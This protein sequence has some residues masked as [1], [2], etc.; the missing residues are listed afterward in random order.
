[1]I[2]S[3]LAAAR[4]KKGLSQAALAELVNTN[5]NQVSRWEIG[6]N[7]PKSSFVVKLADA[8]ETST[9]YLLGRTDNDAPPPPASSGSWLERRIMGLLKKRDFVGIVNEL[10]NEASGKTSNASGTDNQA[11]Q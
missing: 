2:G 3:R 6:E 10:F 7:D 8:L 9:D 4:D 1:M 5:S 11:K